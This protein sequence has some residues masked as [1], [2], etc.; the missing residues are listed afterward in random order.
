MIHLTTL[1][2]VGLALIFGHPTARAG[3]DRESQSP[4]TINLF[5]RFQSEG[6]KQMQGLYRVDP[7]TDVWTQVFDVPIRNGIVALARFRAS[8]DGR[9]IVYNE[10]KE[11]RTSPAVTTV[12]LRDL[13]AGA[14]PRKISN[15]DGWPIWGPEGQGLIVVEPIPPADPKSPSRCVTWRIDD[16]G[17]HRV[18]LPIPETDQ[19]WEWSPDGRWLA[20]DSMRDGIFDLVVMHP[21]G[22]ER[23]E[24]GGS[25]SNEQVRFS[26]DSTRIAYLAS[27]ANPKAG[28]T[29]KS[30]GV[31]NPDGTGRRTI[32]KEA[33]DQHLDGLAWSPDGKQVAT[34]LSTW[35]KIES[36]RVTP[37]NPRLCIIDVADGQ[38]HILTHPP[39]LILGHPE[40][41][42]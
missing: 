37:I 42:R 2:V 29:G 39:A 5:A 27:S 11:S 32:F 33:D 38:I 28:M 41:R 31:V 21:N 4:G 15:I 10:Y 34:V 8:S 7:A 30:V 40:W 19:L 24:I 13:R 23:H 9:R 17:S 22:T 36:G 35:T 3:D 26:P 18:R 20:G 14:E 12:W 1:A 16:D 6:G 25:G